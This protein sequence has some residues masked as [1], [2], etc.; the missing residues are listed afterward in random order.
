MNYTN[1]LL[2]SSLIV[3][4]FCSFFKDLDEIHHEEEEE[5]EEDAEE[6]VARFETICSCVL[7]RCTFLL[8]GV[9][10]PP[11]VWLQDEKADVRSNSPSP[12]SK[13]MPQR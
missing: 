10:G 11:K 1:L 12:S 8:G 6:A 13:F 2:F 3:S 4:V 9:K 7:E 5:E